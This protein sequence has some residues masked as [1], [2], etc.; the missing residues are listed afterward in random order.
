MITVIF[1]VDPA[2]GRKDDYLDI[3][4]QMRPMIARNGTTPCPDYKFML[5]PNLDV[6]RKVHVP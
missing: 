3:A 6:I 2:E 1:E 5:L 4:I